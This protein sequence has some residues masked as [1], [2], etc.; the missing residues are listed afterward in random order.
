MKK[1]HAIKEIEEKWEEIVNVFKQNFSVCEYKIKTQ[2]DKAKLYSISVVKKGHRN[3]STQF[4]IRYN[5]NGESYEWKSGERNGAKAL[6]GFITEVGVDDVFNLKLSAKRVGLL[7]TESIQNKDENN[8][9]NVG[10]KYI[11]KKS[12]NEEKIIIIEEIIDKL[13]LDASVEK[14]II[15]K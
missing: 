15:N 7:I 8:Y 10:G 2:S 5:K 3:T 11:Y 12:E 13:K 4:I 1:E 6:I 9:E 14:N